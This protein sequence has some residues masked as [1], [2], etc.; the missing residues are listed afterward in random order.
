MLV[1]NVFKLAL[2]TLCFRPPFLKIMGIWTST[3]RWTVF[4]PIAVWDVRVNFM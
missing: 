3:K 4:A 1:A 2:L